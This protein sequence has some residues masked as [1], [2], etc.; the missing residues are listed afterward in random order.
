MLIHLLISLTLVKADWYH[1]SLAKE[2]NAQNID[3]VIGKDNY[4]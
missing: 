4:V 3:E 2:L 1:D